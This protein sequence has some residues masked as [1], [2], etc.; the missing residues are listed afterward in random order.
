MVLK[1]VQ[2]SLKE[3]RDHI[4]V[5]RQSW[6]FQISHVKVFVF[7]RRL[8]QIFSSWLPGMH[9]CSGCNWCII[10][11]IFQSRVKSLYLMT[12]LPVF[13]GSW[14]VRWWQWWLHF[15]W[16]VMFDRVHSQLV[17]VVIQSGCVV[18]LHIHVLCSTLCLM[19]IW[20]TSMSEDLIFSMCLDHLYTLGCSS[21]FSWTIQ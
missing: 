19:C 12:F 1:E 2:W 7:V 5:P 4:S 18:K 8:P 3:F 6:M 15:T 14:K 16:G 17:S 20:V 13:Q 21:P 10:Y 9:W 11:S